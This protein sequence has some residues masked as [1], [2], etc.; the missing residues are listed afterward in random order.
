MLNIVH[1]LDERG[2]SL[3]VLEPEITTGGDVGR[4]VITVLGMVAEM[5]RKFILDRQRAGID[6]AKA[7]GIYKGRKRTL[8]YEEIR[9]RKAAGEKISDIAR[10]LGIARISVYRALADKPLDEGGHADQ[11]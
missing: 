4:I 7:A 1:E 2:A 8:P 6:A 5:E 10:T 3:R 9:R 11:A